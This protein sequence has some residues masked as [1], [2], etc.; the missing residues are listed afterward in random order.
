MNTKL[1]L[2]VTA[3]LH[4]LTGLL[5]TFLPAEVARQ[6][7]AVDATSSVLPYQL[8]GAAYLGFAVLNWLSRRSAVGGIF[9]RPLVFANFM[10][11]FVGGFAVVQFAGGPARGTVLP[12]IAAA[13]YFFLAA[14]FAYLLFRKPA[15]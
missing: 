12:W 15:E 8:A 14:C 2:T 4:A 5:L 7:G 9:G 10:Q 6:F 3:I 1:L 11:L 13:A